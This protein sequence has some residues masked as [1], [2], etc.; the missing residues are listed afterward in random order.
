MATPSTHSSTARPQVIMWYRI[1]VLVEGRGGTGGRETSHETECATQCCWGA[2][3]NTQGAEQSRAKCTEDFNSGDK[4]EV[5]V[6]LI[7][8][9]VFTTRKTS[10]A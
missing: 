10:T 2:G 3:W 9:D 4:L 1:M 6:H 8:A 5:E 7:P